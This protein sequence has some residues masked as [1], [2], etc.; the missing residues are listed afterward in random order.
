MASALPQHQSRDRAVWDPPGDRISIV[1]PVLARVRNLYLPRKE[2]WA[3]FS[4]VIRGFFWRALTY[5]NPL[6]HLVRSS[7]WLV[8]NCYSSVLGCWAGRI[9]AGR[10]AGGEKLCSH[11]EVFH[12]GFVLL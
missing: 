12:Y 5:R 4:G 8:N 10:E 2:S 6:R 1:R 3:V 9:H 11:A 7:S